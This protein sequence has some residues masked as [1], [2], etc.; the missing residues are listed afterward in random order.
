MELV[1]ESVMKITAVI[2]IDGGSTL[3]NEGHLG[4]YGKVFSRID[5][6]SNNASKN[7]GNF[8]GEARALLEDGSAIGAT[9][10]GVWKRVGSKITIH[11]LDDASNGDQNYVTAEADLIEMQ[12]QVKVHSL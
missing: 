6:I 2:P 4:K 10:Q 1:A 12:S 3:V 9:L 11:S 7:A 8:S 5:L